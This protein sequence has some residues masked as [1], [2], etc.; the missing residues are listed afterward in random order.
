MK[1][2]LKCAVSLVAIMTGVGLFGGKAGAAGITFSTFVAGSDLVATLGQ[3]NTIAFNYAGNKFVGSVYFGGNNLQLYSTDLNGGSVTKF[4]SPLPSGGGE[5]V[6]GASLGKAGFGPG[7]IY[8]GPSN[9][10][11][12][13]SNSGGSPSLFGATDDGS[14]VRQIF[15]DPGSSFGGKMLVA[16]SSGHILSFDSS[17]AR[18]LVANIGSDTEGMDIA[19]SKYGKYAGQLLVASEGTQLV[20]AVSNAGVV[21][22]LMSSSGGPIL[23]PLAETISTVPLNFG[24]SGNPLEGF[25][26]AN[27]AT[28][29]QKAGIVSEFAPYLGDSIVTSEFGSSS[30]IWD[31]FYNGD[32]ADT[33]TVTQIGTLPGQSEDGIFVTAERII[34]VTTPEPASLSLLGLGALSIGLFARRRRG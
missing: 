29:I 24:L 3:Q 6:I 17:G 4:G 26:V 16:T 27:Y 19:S 1:T 34:D 15:F 7:D 12:R 13:Y 11:Y 23:I 18:T 31:L 9:Q 22:T 32:L 33:F 28:D 30:P 21:T 25:Y 5:V 2:S 14:T 8:A 20:H 10:I